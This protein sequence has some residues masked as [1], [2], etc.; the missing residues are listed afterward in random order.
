MIKELNSIDK[1]YL[2][3]GEFYLSNEPV[4]ISTVLGS[5]IAIIMY[6]DKKKIS[7]IAHCVLPVKPDNFIN[8]EI[9]SEY[10]YVDTAITS[11][12][13]SLHKF[14]VK[15]EE[16]KVKLFGGAEQY[17]EGRKNL[18]VGKMNIETAI[19]TLKR[20]GLKVETLD[21]G[22]NEG[23]KIILFA[24]NGDVYLSRLGKFLNDKNR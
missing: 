6:N 20:E 12:I 24:Q 11:M 16:L 8:K 23:R 2:G 17:F 21:V 9:H 13:N 5:C 14:K 19:N 10:K 1:I 4:I 3:P 18:S 15:K 7:A 22:G